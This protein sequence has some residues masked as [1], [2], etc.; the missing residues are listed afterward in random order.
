VTLSLIVPRFAMLPETTKGTAEEKLK[1]LS[2]VK[3]MTPVLLKEV[4]PPPGKSTGVML[5]VV[6]L[7]YA[8]ANVVKEPGK[9]LLDSMAP[10]L[11]VPKAETKVIELLD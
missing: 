2:L 4:K 5:A 9:A 1:L 3:L 11:A 7:L 6:A 10:L 8:E